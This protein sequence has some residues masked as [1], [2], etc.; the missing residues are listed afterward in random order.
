LNHL[1]TCLLTHKL[2]LLVYLFIYWVIDCLPV[3]L[4]AGLAVVRRSSARWVTED[5][6]Q[7]SPRFIS[8][9]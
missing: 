3:W 6:R 4:L 9:E 8:A 2:Y 5:R 1:F 7:I